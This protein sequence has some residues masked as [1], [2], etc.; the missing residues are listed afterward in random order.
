MHAT[1]T[2]IPHELLQF[3]LF[4]IEKKNQILSFE[5]FNAIVLQNKLGL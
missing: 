3:L 4:S 1:E 2:H 5:I